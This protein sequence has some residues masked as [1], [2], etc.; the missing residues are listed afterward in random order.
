M[1]DDYVATD[2]SDYSDIDDNEVIVVSSGDD[3]GSD[4]PTTQKQDNS[5]IIPCHFCDKVFD[6]I[7]G[8]VDHIQSSHTHKNIRE[9][10]RKKCSS[11]EPNMTS[12]RPSRWK[13]KDRKGRYKC[14]YCPYTTDSKSHLKDHIR[15]HTGEKPFECT[16]CRKR[17]RQNSALK[18]HTKR[19]HSNKK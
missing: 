6:S 14:T 4:T 13:K 17:F 12:T 5:K 11:T 2:A 3:D 19:Y 9:I 8:I 15:V 10:L 1:G 16:I 18:S 7:E